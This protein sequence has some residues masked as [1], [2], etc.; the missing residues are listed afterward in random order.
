MIDYLYNF[1][2]RDKNKFLPKKIVNSINWQLH[3]YLKNNLSNHYHKKV[4]KTNSNVAKSNVI[5]S[6]TS[7]PDRI[8]IIYLSIKSILNQSV[9]PKKVMLWLAESQFPNKEAD[10]PKS[11]LDLVIYGL[12]IKFCEDLKPHKKYYYVFKENPNDIIITVDDDVF[13]PFKTIET[14]IES[15]KKFP[16]SIIANRVRE[17]TYNKGT[18]EPY[19]NWKI[20][21]LNYTDASFKLMATGV[22]GVL[23]QPKLFLDEIYDIEKLKLL[24]FSNDDI[25][26]KANQ[27]KSNLKVVFTNHFFKPFMEIPTSQEVSLFKTNVFHGNNETM[28]QETFSYFDIDESNFL[29]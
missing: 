18:L 12:E 19:R 15:H 25:W 24:A 8:N 27:L 14:L 16:E 17:I 5:V 23:Y 11:L 29:D 26:L 13:Y 3:K 20:N 28:I 22:G 7:F 1:Y 4:I 2:L 10:L 6:L 21:P 9:R